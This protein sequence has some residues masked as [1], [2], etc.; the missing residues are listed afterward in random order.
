MNFRLIFLA[1]GL[2]ILVPSLVFA[3]GQSVPTSQQPP[4][5]TSQQPPAGT[6]QSGAGAN[7]PLPITDPFNCPDAAPN[8]PPCIITILQR[9]ISRM[10]DIVYPILAGIV[11][12]GGFQMM[13]ARGEPEKYKSGVKTI[14]YA[15]IGFVVI[16]LS[17]G[18]GFIL[19]DL[20][21]L[22]RTP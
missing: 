19:V 3:M 4:V 21:S 11:F 17:Q 1:L 2:L 7:A 9:I 15:V 16:L 14:K 6:Q 12:Y 13:F 18:I 10:L 5:G 8:T 22:G 20:V